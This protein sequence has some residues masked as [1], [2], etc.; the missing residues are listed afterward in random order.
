MFRKLLTM[1]AAAL[2]LAATP[3]LAG[4]GTIT[5]NA[6]GAPGNP[7]ALTYANLT[8]AYA[9]TLNSLGGYDITSIAGTV[10]GDKV[11]GLI[12]TEGPATCPCFPE[13]KSALGGI[14]SVGNTIHPDPID[15]LDHG[16]IGF[17]SAG[18]YY[19]LYG[20]DQGL[21]EFIGVSKADFETAKAAGF[22]YDPFSVS[23]GTA[24]L[25]S[26]APEPATWLMLLLGFGASGM[27]LRRDRTGG[28]RRQVRV[29]A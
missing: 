20:L 4:V 18:A 13:G 22:T 19:N 2:A 27:V 21:F 12:P 25:V 5:Y 24:S 26:G 10:N 8:V 16:G 15:F 9:D 3:S 28:G 29:F 23:D 17:Q 14:F 7:L 6:S 1:A 11:T